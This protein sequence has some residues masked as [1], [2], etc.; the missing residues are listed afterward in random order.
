MKLKLFLSVIVIGNVFTGIAQQQPL[1]EVNKPYSNEGKETYDEI[2]SLILENYYFE[3]LSEN[4]LYWA[5][6]QGMLKHISPP[7]SPNLATLWTEE[8]Y[9][10]ILNSLKGIQVTM[11]FNSSFNGNDGSLTVTSLIEGSE[12]EKKLKLQDRIMRID[13]QSLVGISVSEVNKL[14]DGEVGQVS[15]LK[16]IRD[17]NVFEV[18]LKRDTLKTKRLIITNIPNTNQALV[19]IK[20]IS[21]GLTDELDAELRKLQTE[22]VTSVILDFRNNGGGLLNEGINIAR[23]FLKKGSIVL[24]TQSRSSGVQNY[25]V[26]E[27]QYT[28]MKLAILINENTASASEIVAS[29][30]RDHQRALIIGKKS[31]GKAVIENTYTLKNNYRVKF[32]SN[33]M[34][35]PKG[36]SWQSKGILP[37]YFIDQSLNAYKS[38]SKMPIN[39]RLSADLLLSTAIKLLN[40]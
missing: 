20:N 19:E 7:E 22:G 25:A 39:Q 12:A 14:L 34:Y 15:R 21:L 2:K 28:E 3:G 1:F 6:V 30:F 9:E 5:S 38:V 17:I 32:I 23:L 37:D 31:Y 10:K 29:A 36:I 8:E 4:D 27:D 11:G 13:G 18:K 26:S 33:A 40:N 35:S 24:R 16:V